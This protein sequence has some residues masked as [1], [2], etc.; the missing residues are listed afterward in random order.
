VDARLGREFRHELLRL[1]V[2]AVAPPDASIVKLEARAI[3]RPATEANDIYR[4]PAQPEH[5]ELNLW[6]EAFF[7]QPG[8]S[9]VVLPAHL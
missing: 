9:V 6:G 1:L 7:G 2:P 8:G 3:Q 5:V 4:T